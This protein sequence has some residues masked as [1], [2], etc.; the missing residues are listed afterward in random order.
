MRTKILSKYY[1]WWKLHHEICLAPSLVGKNRICFTAGMICLPT[2]SVKGQLFF[3]Y[4]SSYA[5]DI[6][7]EMDDDNFATVLESY[8]TISSLQ[9][10]QFDTEKVQVLD[11]LVIAKKWFCYLRM[12]LMCFFLP[13]SIVSTWCG[14]NPNNCN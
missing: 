13:H 9:V 1:S 5:F 3:S 8:V 7:D 12:P 10:A 6:V 11:H 2:T 4:I 14:I